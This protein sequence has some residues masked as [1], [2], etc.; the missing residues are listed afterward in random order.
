L[1]DT[2][3]PEDLVKLIRPIRAAALLLM[4]ALAACADTP[5]G[6]AIA[7]PDQP[8]AFNTAPTVTVTNSGGNPL[9]SWGALAGATGYSVTLIIRETHTN[10]ETT[11][12]TTQTWEYPLG[13]ATGTSFVD[14]SRPYTGVNR[15]SYL[16]YPWVTRYFYSYRVTASF[17]DGTTSTTTVNAPVAPC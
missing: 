11:E 16:N 17:S 10:R 2:I 3:C 13:S 7:A 6:A 8:A 4:A 1:A 15:C 12:S 14:S 5:T 9:L